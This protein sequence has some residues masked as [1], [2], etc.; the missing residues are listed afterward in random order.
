M[1]GLP[2]PLIPVPLSS[3]DS[4]S[5][6]S[7]DTTQILAKF[8]KNPIYNSTVTLSFETLPEDSYTPPLIREHHD[9]YLYYID[10]HS[11]VEILDELSFSN[12]FTSPFNSTE[13]FR[14]TTS[15]QLIFTFLSLMFL[16][17][18]PKESPKRIVFYINML[19]IPLLN[20]HSF[21]RKPFLT[22]LI[23]NNSALMKTTPIIGSLPIFVK[24]TTS[25][26]NFSKMSLLLLKQKNKFEY[27][28]SF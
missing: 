20:K 11:L 9:S 24:S 22:F 6:L 15:T 19:S 12:T 21:K 1:Y 23:L 17:H 25:N 13:I 2:P 16:P 5:R 10:A 7:P 26:I 27:I 14:E 8:P 28:H 18:F 3:D 4:H